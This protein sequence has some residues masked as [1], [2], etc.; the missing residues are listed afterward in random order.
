[1]TVGVGLIAWMRA[2]VLVTLTALL[3]FLGVIVST[4]A[5]ASPPGCPGTGAYHKHN[6]DAGDISGSDESHIHSAK[7]QI[8]YPGY[9]GN[10]QCD[11]ARSM[12]AYQSDAEQVELG[13]SISADDGSTTQTQGEVFEF[14][15]DL[16]ID[17]QTFF[18]PDKPPVGFASFE[19]A[20]SNVNHTWAADYN[21]N[22]IQDTYQTTMTTA[23]VLLQNTERHYDTDSMAS[24]F[25][26]F[27]VCT[28][29]GCA[30]F[31][32][33]TSNNLY[34]N[35]TVNYVWCKISLSEGEVRSS[36]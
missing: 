4:A 24:H 21:G 32:T 7:D 10:P 12:I 11:I 18:P 26:N 33:P 17:S 22:D 3:G 14:S 25:E 2:T 5:S 13:W 31:H 16:G 1:M 8:N 30:S 6:I 19:L 34:Y 29:S 20:N 36:C 23:T 28:V 15:S 27:S 35:D 9:V